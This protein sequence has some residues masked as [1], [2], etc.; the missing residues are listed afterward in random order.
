MTATANTVAENR[1]RRIAISTLVVALAFGVTKGISLVQTVLIFNVFGVGREWDNFVIA[2]SITDQITNLIG[3]I[4]LLHTFIPIFG[5]YLARNDRAGAWRISSY[6]LNTL[7]LI[8]L[9][10]SLLMILFA[11]ALVA[12]AAPGFSP[13]GQAESVSL[14]RIMAFSTVIMSTSGVVMGILQSHNHFLLPALAPIMLDVGILFGAGVLI[15]PFGIQGVAYGAVLGAMLHLGIQIPGLLRQ[16]LHWQPLL[17]WRDPQLWRLIRLML[18]R[19][20]SVGLFNLEFLVMNN[21][22]SRL[23]EGSVSALSWGWRLMQIPETLI[24]TAL[25]TVIFP[26]LA[27]LSELGDTEGKRGA[28][29]GALRFIMI[30]T[31]PSAIGLILVGQSAISLLEGGAF[32]ASATALVFSTV[33]AFALGLVVHSALEIVARSF[34]ADKDTWTPLLVAVLAAAINI[35]LAFVLSQ[36]NIA[37][38]SHS[39]WFAAQFSYLFVQRHTGDVGGLAMANSLGVAFEVIVLLFILQRRWKG[40]E[41][42]A[43]ARTTLITLVASL[44]MGL[45]I[46]LLDSLWALLG[47]TGSGRVVTLIQI[48]LEMGVGAAVFFVTALALK[49]DE[50][51]TLLCLILRR[52]PVEAVA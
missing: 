28:M 39:T 22:A 34:Y 32:D 31:I 25:G 43:L 1:T 27:A 11:P 20:A 13:A 4:A 41:G 52:Q 10:L 21:V 6:V 26:T 30:A 23:G 2:S 49:L 17:G 51:Q 29:A 48:A 12:G 40:I 37:E 5:G 42:N 15:R 19:M 24:G 38:N 3:G 7:F 8:T 35:V 47:L 46:I 45:A 9:T 18:P 33:R 50:V 16:R 36:V 44:V 14:L